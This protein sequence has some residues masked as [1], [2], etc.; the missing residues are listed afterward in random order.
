MNRLSLVWLPLISTHYLLTHSM[1][2]ITWEAS[3]FSASQEIPRILWNLKVLC[4]IYMCLPPVFLYQFHSLFWA[5]HSW[6]IKQGLGI[7]TCSAGDLTVI[8][9]V[10]L[11]TEVFLSAVYFRVTCCPT[12]RACSPFMQVP[13]CSWVPCW[14]TWE[15]K[16]LVGVGYKLLR[17]GNNLQSGVYYSKFLDFFQF[18]EN[19]Q[20]IMDGFAL[21]RMCARCADIDHFCTKAPWV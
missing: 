18:G 14:G 4:H 2:Q 10:C 12:F 16:A 11:F 9:L 6:A 19:T 17:W 15:H 20:W 13:L 1:E 3:W 8:G 7:V 5:K 21:G